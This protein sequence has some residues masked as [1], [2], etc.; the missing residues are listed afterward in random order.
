MWHW[1]RSLSQHISVT[2]PIATP[3]YSL[4]NLITYVDHRRHIIFRHLILA[5]L[6][7]VLDNLYRKS[8]IKSAAGKAGEKKKSARILFNRTKGIYCSFSVCQVRSSSHTR[9][10]C[11]YFNAR[12]AGF[13][14]LND[15]W[16]HGSLITL[17]AVCLRQ[18]HLT[19]C[20]M[21]V[22][23]HKILLDVPIWYH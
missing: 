8:A 7:S 20:L 3:Q 18:D 15:N 14:R 1:N 2:L 5:W 21:L 22:R 17:N 6:S 4:R 10:T 19:I 9:R 11:C 23:L 13:K 16:A 12:S